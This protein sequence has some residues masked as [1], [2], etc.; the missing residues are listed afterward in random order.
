M[1][2]AWSSQIKSRSITSKVQNEAMISEVMARGSIKALRLTNNDLGLL[3]MKKE[4]LTRK[5]GSN[6]EQIIHR[7]KHYKDIGVIDGQTVKPAFGSASSATHGYDGA[8]GKSIR[9]CCDC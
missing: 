7:Y 3:H 1:N 2:D 9:S 8:A 4:S 6:T 5:S